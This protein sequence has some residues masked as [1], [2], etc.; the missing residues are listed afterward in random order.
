MFASASLIYSDKQLV[1]KNVLVDTGSAGTVFSI[2]KLLEIGMKPEPEDV[3]RELR[4]VGGTEFVFVKKIDTLKLGDFKI[5]DFEI[6]IGAMDYGMEIDGIIGLD[7]LLKV[8]A[9]IDL[10]QMELY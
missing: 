8:K 2:D 7:F 6:E 9:K 10:E 5:T 1:C 4:G 3:I